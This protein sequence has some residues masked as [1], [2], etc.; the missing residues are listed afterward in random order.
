MF[1]HNAIQYSAK[2][3]AI[4]AIIVIIFFIVDVTVI[5]L[6]CCPDAYDTSQRMCSHSFLP[7]HYLCLLGSCQTTCTHHFLLFVMSML[8]HCLLLDCWFL[9]SRIPFFLP[10]Q[11][12]STE[13]GYAINRS[14][15]TLDSN[16]TEIDCKSDDRN[17]PIYRNTIVSEAHDLTPNGMITSTSNHSGANGSV[18][19]M[20]LKNNHL[21]VET[22]ERN[23]SF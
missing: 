17:R 2:G 7:R 19:T 6:F 9:F 11:F 10:F 5:V 20:T 13:S 23:V 4:H 16:D 18:I 22:E 12:K 15:D 21:I 3:S 14:N 8:Y 1:Y